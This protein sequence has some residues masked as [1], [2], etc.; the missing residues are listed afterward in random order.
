M[1]Y[2]S[3]LLTYLQTSPSHLW[4]ASAGAAEGGWPLKG[5]RLAGCWDVVDRQRQRQQI[6]FSLAGDGGKVR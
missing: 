4:G 5:Y 6:G 1:V 3:V 2:V